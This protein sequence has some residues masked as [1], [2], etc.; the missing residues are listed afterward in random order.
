[1]LAY[2]KD[3]LINNSSLIWVPLQSTKPPLLKKL[4]IDELAGEIHE[5]LRAK[6]RDKAVYSY[7][8]SIIF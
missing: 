7:I 2:N 6:K 8:L 3:L 5:N 1:M 4:S